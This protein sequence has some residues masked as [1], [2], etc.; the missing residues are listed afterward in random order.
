LP[1]SKLVLNS[2]KDTSLIS[3][4]TTASKTISDASL[5]ARLITLQDG[6]NIHFFPSSFLVNGKKWELEKDGEMSLS[7]SMVSANDVKFMQGNQQ[8]II[9]TEPSGDGNS[10]DIVVALTK[11]NIDDFVSLVTRQPRLEGVLSG[12]IRV[13]D[14]FG[15][16]LIEYD[17]YADEFRT[18]NDSIGLLKATGSYNKNYVGQ[19]GESD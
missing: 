10:H 5:N 14:P 11:V 1:A 18:D 2:F 8:V 13:A 17:T 16:P 19:P 6:V 3:V 12:N 9:S 7:K 4:N 15:K